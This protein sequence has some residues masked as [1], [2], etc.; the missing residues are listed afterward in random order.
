MEIMKDGLNADHHAEDYKRELIEVNQN[1]VVPVHMVSGGGWAAKIV[2][3]I[4]S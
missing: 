2:E 3:K 1:S 4:K